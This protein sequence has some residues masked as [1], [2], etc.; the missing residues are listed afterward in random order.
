M[1][2]WGQRS[3]LQQKNDAYLAG[4]HTFV[5]FL[6]CAATKFF[7]PCES[8]SG[9]LHL[10]ADSSVCSLQQGYFQKQGVHGA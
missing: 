6:I 7:G 5:G 1:T 8:L 4:Q 2:W 9:V 3:L 10:P